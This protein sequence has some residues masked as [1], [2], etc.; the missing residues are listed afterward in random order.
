VVQVGVSVTVEP[1][2]SEPTSTSPTHDAQLS[3]AEKNRERPVSAGSSVTTVLA[4]KLQQI[5]ST[6]AAA[7]GGDAA[8]AVAAA[9]SAA[10]GMPRWHRDHNV[11][12]RL[13]HLLD[14][15]STRA[16]YPPPR[17]PYRSA[18][19]P[20]QQPQ[21]PPPP[22]RSAEL[23]WLRLGG[24]KD[25]SSLMTNTTVN[26]VL[27]AAATPAPVRDGPE[28]VIFVFLCAPH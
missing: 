11:D 20:Q 3:S 9:A 22:H 14:S 28:C 23:N 17:P 19:M 18:A 12:D 21:P 25:E 10:D 7:A 16:S 13:E 27:A 6:M 4:N 5:E 15:I 24:A 2:N 8:A 26:E 1:E